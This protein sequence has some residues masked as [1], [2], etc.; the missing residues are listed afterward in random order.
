MHQR[1][2]R[3]VGCAKVLGVLVAVLVVLYLGLML[4]GHLIFGPER[5]HFR[6]VHA[7]M[8]ESEVRQLLGEPRWT[9]TSQDAPSNYYVEG[10]RHKA[11]PITGKVL[12]YAAS[13]S[14]AYVYLD[15]HGRVEEVFVGGS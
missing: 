13:E 6:Q 10:Y 14:I 8:A 11:R 3:V 2:K 12:I 5:A 9:F 7:G 15:Q 4:A 1:S